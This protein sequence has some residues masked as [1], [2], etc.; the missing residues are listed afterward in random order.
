MLPSIMYFVKSP[1]DISGRN[2]DIWAIIVCRRVFEITAEN[3]RPIGSEACGARYRSAGARGDASASVKRRQLQ[4]SRPR[5]RVRT[6]GICSFRYHRSC[7][8]RSDTGDCCCCCL[9]SSASRFIKNNRNI[10]YTALKSATA[11]AIDDNITNRID[12]EIRE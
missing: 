6:S 10:I 11:A 12:D 3:K 2:D 4:S 5:T 7:G 1:R 9:A 8:S